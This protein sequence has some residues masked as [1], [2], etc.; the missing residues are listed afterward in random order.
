MKIEP[1]KQREG[2]RIV[3]GGLK[4]DQ[5]VIINGL[6]RARPGIKVNASEHVEEEA[7][8]EEPA[9]ENTDTPTDDGNE[10]E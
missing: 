8:P 1:G 10:G 5:K 6:Q 3:L 7:A 9:E 4:A 2:M